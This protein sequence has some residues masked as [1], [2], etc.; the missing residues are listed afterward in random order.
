MSA[1]YSD[2]GFSDEEQRQQVWAEA[3]DHYR[4]RLSIEQTKGALMFIYGIDADEAFD[5]LRSHSQ[6]HNIKLRVIAEQILKDLV[7]LSQPK[8]PARR[9][10]FD[11][12]MLTA[13]H[14]VEQCA[15]RQLDGQS[16][17][18]VPMKDISS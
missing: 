17:T 3:H 16:K 11:G 8:G 14:R 1:E 15:P 10:A 4:N 5:I 9:M 13:R 6:A 7:E 2:D 18:G 12:L